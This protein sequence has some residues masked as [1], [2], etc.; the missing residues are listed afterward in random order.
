MTLLELLVVLAIFGI[1]STV[2]IFNYGNFQSEI[3][4]KNLASDIALQVVTAQKS[5]VYGLLPSQ[6][7]SLGWKPS[8]GV[9]FSTVSS[10]GADNKDFIYFTDLNSDGKFD[11]SSCPATTGECISKY[12]I[13]NNNSISNISVACPSPAGACVAG[14]IT[15]L[16]ITF[17]RPD[18]GAT[19]YNSVLGVLPANVSYVEITII[20]SADGKTTS[21]IDLY[22]SG[23]VQIN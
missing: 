10:L 22:P 19:F 12:T 14:T 3:Y 15:N 13:T 21:S 9:Y 18:S 20:S 16:A 2:V 6:S 23:R 8:Y 5:A 17:T 11:G 1:L 4:I 7:Y